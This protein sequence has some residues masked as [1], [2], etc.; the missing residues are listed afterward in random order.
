MP[1]DRLS[2][3]AALVVLLVIPM[4]FSGYELFLVTSILVMTIALTGMNLL[5]GYGGLLSLGHG[6]F[7]AI[8][9]YA[10]VIAIGRIGLP[11]IVAPLAAG[12]VCL[13]VGLAFSIPAL[14][15]EGMQLALTTF[16]LA[17]VVPQ[18]LRSDLFAGWTGGVQG[19]YIDKP[20]PPNW[21]S[22][23]D[24][25]WI[26]AIAALHT[27]ILCGAALR[28]ARGRTGR[29]L[30][31]M[32][33]NPIAAGA[34]AVD[35]MDVKRRVFGASAFYT[36]VAGAISAILLQFVAPDSFHFFL[37]ISLFVGLAV[38]GLASPLGPLLG[39]AFVVLVPNFAEE[40]S[41][42]ATGAVYG[43]VVI[44]MMAVEPRGLAGLLARF[45]RRFVR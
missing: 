27:V 37:S 28:I 33:D 24:D 11:V 21:L 19:V 8:G 20:V 43:A 10:A 45:A 34:M 38:G 14:R 4:A 2:F 30:I 26:Y 7:Y 42:A 18:V 6:A 16:A 29:A 32:R 3:A 39:A 23:S 1:I 41:Q 9:A 15:L 17:I 25:Q 31:A 22:V 44:L 12:C 13:V 5:I 40:V 36:G 35:I